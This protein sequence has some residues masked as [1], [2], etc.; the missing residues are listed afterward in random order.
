MLSDI[1]I[2]RYSRQIILPQVGGKGQEALLQSRVLVNEKGLL[3]ATTFFYLAAAGIGTIGILSDT[4][5]PSFFSALAAAQ[6]A[7]AVL[8]DLNPDCKIVRHETTQISHFEQLVQ[9]Y[10]VVLSPYDEQLHTACYRQ[11]R[12]FLCAETNQLGGWLFFSQGYRPDFPCL[13]CLST[14]LPKDDPISVR[15]SVRPQMLPDSTDEWLPMVMFIGT[16]QTTEVLK[17]LLGTSQSFARKLWRCCF[18]PLGF[19]ERLIEKNLG[20]PLCG[21]SSC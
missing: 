2:E 15:L 4:S 11:S 13:R 19:S 5:F 10:D 18:F 7:S 16:L 12:P 1:Q 6:D 14:Q 20:C 17:L 8:S 3:Q 21:K 9:E